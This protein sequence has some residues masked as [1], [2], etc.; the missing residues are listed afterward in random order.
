MLKNKNI[1]LYIIISFALSLRLYGIN[2]EVPHPDDYI[3]VQ[4]AM[5][6][7]PPQVILNEYGIYALY[8]W[9]AFSLV[10]IQIL[11]FTIYFSFGWLIGLFPSLE[12]FRFLYYT[13]PHS[14]YLIGRLMSVSFAIATIWIM[15][16]FG[17]R[18]YNHKVG[19]L[20]S[21]FLSVSFIHCF[22]SQF[23]RPDIPSTFLIILILMSCMK[24]MELKDTK[25]YLYAGILT[26]LATAT[27][28]TSAM[29]IIPILMAHILA[30]GKDL[31]NSTRV[32]VRK[33]IFQ[34]ILIVL[35][36]FILVGCLLA[37]TL[38]FPHLQGVKFSP[39]AIVNKHFLIFL[40]KM[41]HIGL[42]LGSF[43]TLAGI[44]SAYSS[45]VKNFIINLISSKKLLSCAVAVILSFIIFD[46]LFFIDFKNQFRII[47]TDINFSGMNNPVIGAD[48]LGF[49]GN[50]VWYIKGG[51]KW[52]LGLHFEIMAGFGLLL[53]VYRRQK[54][55]I[56]IFS[57]LGIYFLIIMSGYLKWDRYVI[58]LMPFVA[59]YCAKFID[60]LLE[61]ILPIKVT[62]KRRNAIFICVAIVMILF[63]IINILRYDYLITQKDTRTIA[64]EWI[65][66][67][68]SPGSKIGQDVYT[69]NISKANFK[70]LKKY[71]LSEKDLSQYIN[72]GFDYLIVSD[73][74][75]KRY[76]AEPL[77]YSENV[78]FYQELFE[79]GMLIKE[80]M[81]NSNLWPKAEE[82]F[83]IYHIHAS[84]IIKIY[85]INHLR[86][87]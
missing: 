76:F 23:I 69:G 82:R 72:E 75:Y 59:L 41:A 48:S 11:L 62:E 71:S 15:Y 55:D 49:W 73:T 60:V 52:G 34:A 46:P 14:F 50:F 77:K 19:L 9:P 22:H 32:F 84:P 74:Q 54:K 12:S 57:F 63:P 80:F 37:P 24:I 26:G 18:L 61:K 68:I 85:Q 13:D 20:A 33:Y 38:V 25:Y 83:L 8:N 5:H 81:E 40:N 42:L 30:E 7:G 44:F 4:G 53:A 27:K 29:M 51:L 58:P 67:N 65:Q 47:I 1:I 28:F 79:S 87:I 45:A 43:I 36:A 66:K 16:Y 35:G 39:N 70:I 6:F 78:K 2:Y 56:L 64:K 10:Y 31:F 3:T 21:L 17:K 86:D